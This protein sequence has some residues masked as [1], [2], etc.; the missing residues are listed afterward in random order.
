MLA[1]DQLWRHLH[2][3]L[4]LRLSLGLGGCWA[5]LHA[6]FRLLR[7]ECSEGC[8]NRVLQLFDLLDIALKTFEV[9]IVGQVLILQHLQDGIDLLSDALE[10]I[11]RE[12]TCDL[13]VLTRAHVSN[14]EADAV[15]TLHKAIAK[16]TQIEE[17]EEE[18]S[19]VVLISIDVWGVVD[20]SLAELAH[21]HHSLVL[22][23]V[24]ALDFLQVWQHGFCHE[25]LREH[26]LHNFDAKTILLHG[27][28]RLRDL[29]RL[30]L[31]IAESGDQRLLF[32]KQDRY[33]ILL[34]SVGSLSQLLREDLDLVQ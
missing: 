32:F 27:D 17:H 9:V 8:L 24:E 25:R 26:V 3:S 16:H 19:Q 28:L 7:C 10:R 22:N 18:R 13:C 31:G 21:E 6:F 1:K 14:E 4:T 30:L 12:N 34:A 2:E 11:P 29:Q 23:E 15:T 5:K 33:L 20:L